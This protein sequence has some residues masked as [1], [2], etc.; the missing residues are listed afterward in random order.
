[1]RDMLFSVHG[2]GTIHTRVIEINGTKHREIT[3]DG[4]EQR[5]T[6][7]LYGDDLALHAR[8]DEF[9]RIEDR[10]PLVERSDRPFEVVQVEAVQ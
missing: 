3:I 8:A 4:D 6:I 10:H 1:M 9:C 2:V 7:V 5:I